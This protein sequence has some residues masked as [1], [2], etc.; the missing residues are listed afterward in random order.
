MTVGR[1][2]YYWLTTLN[3]RL[4]L[5][6]RLNQSVPIRELHLVIC[7]TVIRATPEQTAR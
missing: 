6:V 5:A 2:L 4:D 1:Q 7:M 3:V